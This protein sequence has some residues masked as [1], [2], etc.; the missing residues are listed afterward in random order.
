MQ[1]HRLFALLT[2]AISCQTQAGTLCKPQ[3]LVFYSCRIAGT[4]KLV[5]LCGNTLNDPNGFWLQYR[6][7][8][9]GKLELVHPKGRGNTVPLFFESGFEVAHLRRNGGWDSEISFTSGGW[10]YTVISWTPGEGNTV[11]T[12][13]IFVSK[14]R[15][16]PGTTLKCASAPNYGENDAFTSLVSQ[17]GNDQ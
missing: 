5:S 13:G 8:M 14:N 9:L 3:E 4:Q 15:S 2:V 17:Y 7:G 12:E 1:R 6:F 11:R 16:G 10:S